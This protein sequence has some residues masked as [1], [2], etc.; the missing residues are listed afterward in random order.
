MT[1]KLE[2]IKDKEARVEQMLEGVNRKQGDLVSR[3]CAVHAE[4][5][6]LAAMLAPHQ[7]R[8]IAS[9]CTAA[10]VCQFSEAV[11]ASQAQY[12]ASMEALHQAI[13]NVQSELDGAA[14]EREEAAFEGNGFPKMRRAA[15]RQ[16]ALVE[17]AERSH[18]GRL[19]QLRESRATLQEAMG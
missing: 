1:T 8:E 12:A 2:Q 5:N 17:L 7:E 14:I 10:D 3:W 18:H 16:L 4:L 6:E 9:V 11:T 13:A 19:A 15:E